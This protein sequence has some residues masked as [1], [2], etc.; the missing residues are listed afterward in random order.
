MRQFNTVNVIIIVCSPQ[1][2]LTEY[3]NVIESESKL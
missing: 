3:I 2:F 1:F